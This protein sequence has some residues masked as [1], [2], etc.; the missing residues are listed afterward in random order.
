MELVLQGIIV[1]FSNMAFKVVEQ[2]LTGKQW[3]ISLGF[4]AITFVVSII[5]K[6]IPLDVCI[7]NM[8]D[9]SE[10]NNKVANED[11]IK[12]ATNNNS[13]EKLYKNEDEIVNVNNNNEDQ[14][15]AN[16]GSFKRGG[17]FKAS[18]RGNQGALNQ[19]TESYIRKN[20]LEV[21][22]YSMSK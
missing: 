12:E 21:P 7:Q 5:A 2:G 16:P 6:L 8:L 3:G 10:K 11:D 4:S 13:K 22:M 14:A 18:L 1:Q 17:G 15:S 20:K 9:N 19:K